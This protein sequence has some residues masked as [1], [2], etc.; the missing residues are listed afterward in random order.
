MDM[1]DLIGKRIMISAQTITVKDE[2]YKT[3]GMVRGITQF[4]NARPNLQIDVSGILRKTG[5]WQSPFG[6]SNLI[7][8]GKKWYYMNNLKPLEFYEKYLADHPG[9]ES[10]KNAYEQRKL[11]A[12]KAAEYFTVIDCYI[13]D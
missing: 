11:M 5:I 10:D 2:N 3:R 8:D 7:Y 12:E 6:N 13:L 4:K 1:L 9:Y